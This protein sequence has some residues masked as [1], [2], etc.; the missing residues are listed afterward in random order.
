MTDNRSPI[1]DP[2]S[3]LTDIRAVLFDAGGTLIHVDGE[4]VCQAVGVNYSEPLFREAEAAAHAQAR[5]WIARHPTS[6]DAQRLPIFLEAMLRR[7]GIEE[8]D[9]LEAAGRRVAAEHDRA[10]LWCRPGDGAAATLESLRE[11]GYRL[12]VV[13]N[14]NG[15]VRRLL[16]R[17]GLAPFFEIIVDSAEVGIEKPDPRI[18]FAATAPLGLEPA[19][20]AY[21]GDIYEIDVAGAKAA[22]LRPILIGSA[23]APEPVER[24]ANLAAMLDLFPGVAARETP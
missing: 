2:R 10:N 18:F 22:G 14:S 23:P 16:E 11:R 5:D 13:S 19:L 12:G 24:V 8:R 15:H 3:P 17:A 6:T 21:V 7:L 1:T 4:S 9:A 20:C